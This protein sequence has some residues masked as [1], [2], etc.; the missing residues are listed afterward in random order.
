MSGALA[1]DFRKLTKKDPNFGYSRWPYWVRIDFDEELD[2]DEA[3]ILEIANPR[4]QGIDLYILQ[5]GTWHHVEA[6]GSSL[7]QRR[8]SLIDA[9][10]AFR[11]P[12]A[13]TKLT[14][15]AR[16]VANGSM[17]FPMNLW[18]FHEF[19]RYVNRIQIFWGYTTVSS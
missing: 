15:Y 3:W 5:N 17:D 1:Q 16:I 10:F 2:V 4:L 6:K 12:P 18:S 8:A 11:L 19:T 7:S 9:G 13:T 14:V